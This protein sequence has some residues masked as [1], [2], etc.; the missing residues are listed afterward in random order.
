MYDIVAL[1]ELLIDFLSTGRSG[2][3]SLQ[4]EANPGGAPCNVLAAA[5]R[6]GCRTAFI[7]KV[8]QDFFGRLLKKT[9]EEE[10]IDSAGLVMT[11]DFFTTL[12]FVTLDETGNR[13]FSFSRKNSADVMLRE[14]EVPVAMIRDSRMF[15]CGTLSL[16]DETCRR[17]TVKALDAAKGCG[18][19][20]SV[21]PNLR[22]PLWPD[23]E[24]AR[25][26]MK[27]VL[28]YADIVKMSDYE[29]NFLYGCE[30][31]EGNTARLLSRC[32]MKL[33]F[34]TC[35]KDGAY[36]C[37]GGRKIYSPCFSEVKTVDT[38]GAGDAFCGAALSFLL[39]RGL[40]LDG[41]T[42]GDCR[43]LLRYASAAA[44]LATTKYGA[45]PAM[46]TDA[47]IRALLGGDL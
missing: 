40:S 39:N 1:G 35:G 28:H 17:A 2:R 46:P 44:S 37:Y 7:G 24:S 29:V 11:P 26:A 33:L 5:G 34:V 22:E 47:E 27:T 19:V 10:H 45:I 32:G 30:D 14:D 20:I 13:N 6:L 43:R 4:F 36:C 38:T 31:L 25:T 3:G 15:H 18:T 8:G 23:E 21:D 16:T 42:D 41:L 12:A 9:L